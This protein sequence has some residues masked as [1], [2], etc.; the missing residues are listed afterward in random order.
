M[1]DGSERKVSRKVRESV[2]LWCEE[3]FEGIDSQS[4]MQGYHT[5]VFKKLVFIIVC[6]VAM[7]IAAGLSLGTGQYHIEFLECY[8][9]VFDHITGNVQDK[10][11]DYFVVDQRLPRIIVGI[12]TGAGLAA[13]GCVMQS[14]MKNPLADP[15]T[16]GISSGASFGATMAMTMGITI[17]AGAYAITMNAFVF[18][19]IPMVVIVAVSKLNN[20][21]PV[22]MIMAGIAIMYIFNAI[23]SLMKLIADPDSLQALYNW[24]VGT[25]AD[26]DSWEGVLLIVAV[27]IAGVIILQFMTR[28]LNILSTGDDSAKS[29]GLNVDAIRRA[30][31]L[32][33]TLVV[34]TVVSFTGLI[35]FVGLVAPHIGR[36]FVGSDNRYLLPSSAFFGATL[37]V[38]ADLVGRNILSH[39]ELQVGI[40]TAFI[41]GPLF[42]YLIIKQQRS[43]W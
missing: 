23:T 6:V 26:I 12:A 11:L 4:I 38:I 30:L 18:A 20:S 41:G 5:S 40:I 28:T 16:T 17:G 42:L 39:G 1:N 2:D 25:L 37:L 14:L 15:Y 32:L 33:I 31:L 13:C 21:S 34:A 8:R 24:Q 22:T 43:G 27:V 10:M 3:G 35:G 9:I 36:L 7:F 29:M 19:L